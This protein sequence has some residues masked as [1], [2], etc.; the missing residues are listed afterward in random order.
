MWEEQGTFGNTQVF[1]DAPHALAVLVLE[2][3]LIGA[4]FLVLPVQLLHGRPFLLHHSDHLDLFRHE[5]LEA[6]HLLERVHALRMPSRR[7]S[8]QRQTPTQSKPQP[9]KPAAAARNRATSRFCAPA[10]ARW[11]GHAGTW[12]S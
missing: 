9:G 7:W 6:L 12:S 10:I 11:Q 8:V 1:V 5:I 3:V 4:L 2:A